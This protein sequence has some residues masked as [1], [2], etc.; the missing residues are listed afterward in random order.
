MSVF[1][2]LLGIQP[3][4]GGVFG[5][6]MQQPQQGFAAPRIDVP[7]QKP[8]FWQTPEFAST[9]TRLG[10]NLAAASSQNEDF[11]TGLS[12]ATAQT[13]K[14]TEA[15]RNQSMQNQLIQAQINKANAESRPSSPFSG[16]GFENQ[17]A[18]TYYQAYIAQGM[19]P[20]EAQ[21]KAAQAVFNREPT[22]VQMGDKLVPIPGRTLPNIGGAAPT[23]PSMASPMPQQSDPIAQAGAAMG[24]PEGTLLPPPSGTQPMSAMPTQGVLPAPAADVFVP[25][26]IPQGD[27]TRSGLSVPQVEGAGENTMQALRQATGEAEI[28]IQKEG[29]LGA[30]KSATESQSEFKTQV[31]QLPMLYDV[32]GELNQ[33]ANQATFTL[34]QQG[35][36]FLATRIAGVP[37]E[38]DTARQKYVSTVRNVVLPLLRSTFGAQFTAKEGESLLETLGSPDATPQAKQA[39]LNSFIEQKVRNLEVS[40]RESG[41]QIPAGVIRVNAPQG[42]IQALQQNPNLAADFDAK[43]GAGSAARILG[44]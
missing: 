28:A 29:A 13:A 19:S 10:A 39:V 4:S 42:A 12:L 38:G 36:D 23:A 35:A 22:F 44:Q 43:Y 18:G 20:M 26:A 2:R 33:L 11:L 40:A 16:T 27:M 3:Q 8:K 15:A 5:Q 25:Q 41:L 37:T 1:Q 7:Q 24:F 14:D 31:A 34:P 6:L 32:V 17:V 9:L 30:A 21:I